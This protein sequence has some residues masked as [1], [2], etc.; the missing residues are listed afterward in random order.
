MILW[1]H[2]IEHDFYINPFFENNSVN[3]KLINSVNLRESM[4]ADG[5]KLLT[6]LD[7]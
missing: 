1:L 2:K 7:G 3:L 4:A 6:F 5:P